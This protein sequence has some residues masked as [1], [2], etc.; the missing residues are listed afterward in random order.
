MPPRLRRRDRRLAA[1]HE[2]VEHHIAL[3]RVE[4]DQPPR[5]LYRERRG[6]ANWVPYVSGVSFSTAFSRSV[7]SC[8]A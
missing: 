7:A 3:K 2:R 8:V 1:S 4:L 6:V 5:K